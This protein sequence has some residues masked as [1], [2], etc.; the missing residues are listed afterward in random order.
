MRS[1]GYDRP[2]ATLEIQFEGGGVYRYQGVP[3]EIWQGLRQAASKGKFF[4]AHVRD[5]FDTSRVD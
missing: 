1:I 3:V 2:T 4:Q 5:R